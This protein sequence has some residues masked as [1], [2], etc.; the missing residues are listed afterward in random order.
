MNGGDLYAFVDDPAQF[1][2]YTPGYFVK[3]YSQF[4]DNTFCC[5][6][7]LDNVYKSGF[8]LERLGKAW[9]Y[10]CFKHSSLL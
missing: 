8:T 9:L 4:I 10:F 2:K 6:Q 7:K 5:I 3:E 1:D